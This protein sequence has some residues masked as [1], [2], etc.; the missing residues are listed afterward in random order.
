MYTIQCT[1]WPLW[2]AVWAAEALSAQCSLFSVHRICA[3]A[4]VRRGRWARARSW[5][6][7]C[8]SGSRRAC[9]RRPRRT[10]AHTR[11]PV[12]YSCAPAPAPGHHL[13]SREQ[14][15]LRHE[16]R[17]RVARWPSAHRWPSTVHS[18]TPQRSALKRASCGMYEATCTTRS[19]RFA[20][21]AQIMNC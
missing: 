10:C 5:A 19:A 11:A 3:R 15:A 21:C 8:R 1:P 14:R 12:H 20:S 6:A 18:E 7:C 4:P 2:A 13:A 9:S 16:H 17:G